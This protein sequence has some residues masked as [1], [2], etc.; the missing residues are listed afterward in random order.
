MVGNWPGTGRE[1]WSG[2]VLDGDGLLNASHS[3]FAPT[4][5]V[6]AATAV[7]ILRRTSSTNINRKTSASTPFE[8]CQEALSLNS[9]RISA[10]PYGNRAMGNRGSP[11]VHP[12]ARWRRSVTPRY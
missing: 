4:S 8:E 6:K 10:N 7:V 12:A 1:M 2:G 9:S 3:C 11:E 5:L